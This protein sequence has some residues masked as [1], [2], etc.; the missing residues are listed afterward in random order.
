MK[1]LHAEALRMADHIRPGDQIMW[2]QVCGEPQTLTEALVAQRAEIGKVSVFLGAGFSRT[3]QPEHADF[4]ALR[5][6][7]AVG[8]HRRLT[9][10]GVLDVVPT[11]ISQMDRSIRSGTI[12]CDVALVQVSPANEKGEHSYGLIG[13]YVRAMVESARVVIAE[14]NAQVPWVNCDAPLTAEDIDFAIETDRPL[15]EVPPAEASATDEAIAAF[16]EP[17]IPD[18]ATLQVGIGGVPEAIMKLLTGRSG[19]GIHSGMIGESVV[20]LIEAGAVTNEHKEIDR[21]VMVTGALLGTERLYRFCER[22]PAIRMAPTSYTHSMAVLAKL[23][24]FI[25][26]NS[27]LEVD[28]TGQVNA[29]AIGADYLG[30]VGGQVDYVRAANVSEGGRSI[31][32]LRGTAQDGKVSR[33]VPALSGPVTTARADVDMIVTEFGVAELRGLSLRERIRA[34]AAIAAPQFR[35]DLERQAHRLVKNT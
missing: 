16:I 28:I 35:E 32:A 9:K 27:A 31:I 23:S 19:L 7:G 30:A 15:I 24:R 22:N 26:M 12:R 17:L 1:L 10:A 21:G 2:G 20:D 34:M 13:D 5:G 14:I 8:T 25:S 29:E 11:H 3:L 18:R 6:I 33:I 4:I